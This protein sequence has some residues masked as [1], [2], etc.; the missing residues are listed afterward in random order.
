MTLRIF[1]RRMISI[2]GMVGAAGAAAAMWAGPASATDTFPQGL[3]C[4][5][6]ITGQIFIVH[7]IPDVNPPPHAV[8]LRGPNQVATLYGIPCTG[9][10]TNTC[11]GL[12]RLQTANAPKVDTSLRHYP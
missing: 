10:N 12:S 3:V 6:T 5:N 1:S 4:P 11:I 8:N 7:C 2:A 9:A